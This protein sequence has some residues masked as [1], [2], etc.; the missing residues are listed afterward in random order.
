MK[1]LK[2]C[3]SFRLVT[4]AQPHRCSTKAVVENP[5]AVQW[6]GLHASTAEGP[7]SIPGW[8]TEIPQVMQCNQ[9]GKRQNKTSSRRQVRMSLCPSKIY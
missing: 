2:L 3:W 7:G 5:L 1:Y 9:S 4:T 6:L 8:G